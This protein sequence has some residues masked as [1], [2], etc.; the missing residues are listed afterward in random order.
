LGNKDIIEIRNYTEST[1]QTEYDFVI[2]NHLVKDVPKEYLP[3]T[4]GEYS[5]WLVNVWQNLITE[6]LKMKDGVK[7]SKYQH[8]CL[9]YN[10]MLYV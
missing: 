10:P 2:E 3:E 7:I 4:F 9:C 1:F 8:R 5:T 6:I